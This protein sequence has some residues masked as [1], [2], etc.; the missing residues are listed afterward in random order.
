[1]LASI[2][3]PPPD[4]G[5]PEHLELGS[6]QDWTARAVE[7]EQHFRAFLGSPAQQ[8]LAAAAAAYFFLCDHFWA[9][10]HQKRA[11]FGGDSG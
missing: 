2:S 1:M 3:V 5:P 8:P 9:R 7:I 10:F 11:N 6:T 4:L